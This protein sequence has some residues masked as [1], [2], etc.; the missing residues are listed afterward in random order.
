MVCRKNKIQMKLVDTKIYCR[1]NKK[2]VGLMPADVNTE[3]PGA[4]AKS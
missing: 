1:R 2:M 3:E 4:V